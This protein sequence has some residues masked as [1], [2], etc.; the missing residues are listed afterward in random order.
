MVSYSNIYCCEKAGMK[1]K[2]T[3]TFTNFN[4]F[5]FVCLFVFVFVFNRYTFLQFVTTRKY[6]GKEG[7]VYYRRLQQSLLK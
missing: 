1:C 6:L 2:L 5:L 3:A 4:V 7:L